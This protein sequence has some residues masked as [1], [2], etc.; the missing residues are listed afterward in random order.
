[1]IQSLQLP[2]PLNLQMVCTGETLKS[3]IFA[4][5]QLFLLFHDFDKHYSGDELNSQAITD[6]TAK[7][8]YLDKMFNLVG[9]CV[10]RVLDVRA[11]K[12]VAGLEPE[13]TCAFLLELA[14]CASNPNIDSPAAVSRVLNGEE[15]GTGYVIQNMH[16]HSQFPF[17]DFQFLSCIFSWFVFIAVHRQ[18]KEVHRAIGVKAKVL[19]LKTFKELMI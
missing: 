19:I 3:E 12:V 11:A 2:V 14:R 9:V 15:A 10:G 4:V 7:I 1:M 16:L 6:R 13:C 18:R 8:D 5:T 17:H